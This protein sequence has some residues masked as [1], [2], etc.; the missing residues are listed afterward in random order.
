MKTRA[1][2]IATSAIV[3]ALTASLAPVPASSA[4]PIIPTIESQQIGNM[5]SHLTF[6]L[7]ERLFFLPLPE[8]TSYLQ[9]ITNYMRRVLSDAVAE[10]DLRGS[11]GKLFSKEAIVRKT[12]MEN[13]AHSRQ[14]MAAIKTV[15]QDDYL[16]KVFP[17]PA[18][19][20]EYKTR[21][22]KFGRAVA[23]NLYT[24]EDALSHIDQQK[25]PEATC[26]M[27]QP[28]VSEVKALIASEHRK[29]GLHAPDWI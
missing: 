28:D 1:K 9:T 17:D 16:K 13:I 20:E 29:L 11:K 10:R 18:E 26:N 2:Q 14:I 7:A 25:S 21:L 3:A 12:L 8:A 5:T 15:V 22:I 23:N 27:P 24:T 6:D 19:R 4:T